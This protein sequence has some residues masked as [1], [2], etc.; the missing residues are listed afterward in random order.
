MLNHEGPQKYYFE[1]YQKVQ[2]AAYRFKEKE[3]PISYVTS[4]ARRMHLYPLEDIL[5]APYIADDWNPSLIVKSME[6]I[7]PQNLRYK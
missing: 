2:E 4:L 1:E 3:Q 5:I 6:H 7:K